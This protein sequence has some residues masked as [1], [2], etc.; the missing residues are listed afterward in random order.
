M[1]W[2]LY[3]L[4][5]RVKAPLHIGKRKIGNLMQTYPYVT[6][7]AMWGALTAAITRKRYLDPQ[8]EDYEGIGARLFPSYF[9]VKYHVKTLEE[10]PWFPWDV[11]ETFSYHFLDARAAIATEEGVKTAAEGMLYQIEFIAPHTRGGEPVYL[12]G[13]LATEEKEENLR[14]WIRRIQV[15]G[16]LGYGWGVLELHEL[17]KANALWGQWELDSEKTKDRVSKL[18]FKKAKGNHGRNVALAHVYAL[19]DNKTSSIEAKGR[20]E[21][22]VAWEMGSLKYLGV[23]YPPGGQLPS[24]I[25]KIQVDRYGFWYL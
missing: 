18:V 8:K 24:S 11:P 15:G 9:Y 2:E 7:R 23:F 21:P 4:T 12:T 6:G 1:S 10:K 22:L 3:S 25:E 16:E 13:Y 19:G 5:F 17:R 14:E 20:A